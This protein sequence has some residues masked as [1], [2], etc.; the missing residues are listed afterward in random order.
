MEDLFK[1][2][3]ERLPVSRGL[4]RRAKI[5]ATL[6]SSQHNGRLVL[7]LATIVIVCMLVPYATCWTLSPTLHMCFL[8]AYLSRPS[9]SPSLSRTKRPS[10]AKV[11]DFKRVRFATRC[12]IGSAF[13]SSSLGKPEL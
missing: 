11:H 4:R 2:L 13:T 3:C 8:T 7:V 9:H 6:F 5:G 10:L 1:S 12:V